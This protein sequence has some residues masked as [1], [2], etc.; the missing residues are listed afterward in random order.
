MGD[1]P[2]AQVTSSLFGPAFIVRQTE[3]R[4]Q[5]LMHQ[6]VRGVVI[7]LQSVGKRMEVAGLRDELGVALEAGQHLGEP[8]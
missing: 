6:K 5:S 8:S 1:H 4:H 7:G 2:A 3:R